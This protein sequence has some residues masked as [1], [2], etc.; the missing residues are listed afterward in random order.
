MK[1]G[2]L[3]EAWKVPIFERHL[4]ATDLVFEIADKGDGVVYVNV[5]DARCITDLETRTRALMVLIEALG[6][7]VATTNRPPATLQ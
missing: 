4:R 6:E 5:V 7:A 2:V 1:L 3:T